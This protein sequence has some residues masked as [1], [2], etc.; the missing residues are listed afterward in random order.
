MNRRDFLSRT[1]IAAAAGLGLSAF[2]T[3][4]ASAADGRKKRILF[5][6]KS[7]GFEHPAIKITNGMPG[8]GERILRELADK[9]G[10]EV[11]AT[12]D[13]TVFTPENIAKY[14]AFFF[15]T[16][17]DLTT[18]GTD[19]QPPMTP[20][21]KAAFLEAIRS[22]KGFIG[23]HSATDTF[24][25]QPDP[26]DRSARLVAHGDAVDPYVK[27]IGAEFISHGAQQKSKMTVVDPSFPGFK[28]VDS[29][30]MHEEWYTLKDYQPNL[31]VL[32]VQET[33]GMTGPLYQRRP[34]PAT[35]AR[36]H[37]RGRVFYTSMGH[38]D[39]VWENPTFQS[40]LLGGIS[41]ALRNVDADVTPNLTKV[42]PH[43][44]DLPTAIK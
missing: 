6:T 14:D 36:M 7:S 44:G 40:I 1:G 16:T 34:Y 39:D 26:A 21:G 32:L 2:P 29:F 9:H 35:W 18:P 37:G 4:W 31:H 17:G 24:H 13:G 22:G 10:F 27:M 8:Y 11:T 28:G 19:K 42:T 15:Y 43:H 38:R 5:F 30:T 41:W 3:G 12:K 33:E 23:S 25:F 20:E